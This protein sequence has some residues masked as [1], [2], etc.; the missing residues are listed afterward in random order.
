MTPRQPRDPDRPDPYVEA[1]RML[2]HRELSTA[3]I[4]ERLRERGHADDRTALVIDRL[5][6]ERALD[7]RRTALACARTLVRLK[8][9]GRLRV[10]RELEAR[11]IDP[12]TA[13]AAA[14]EV[15]SEIDERDVL[16]EALS[17]RL[18]G[19]IKDA[20]E[21]RRLY[22]YLIRQGFSA[23]AAIEALKAKAHRGAVPEP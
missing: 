6:R 12:A 16:T 10:L 15:F 22:A 7:D 23:A 1:L 3:E 20:G 2:A 13:R 21:F 18:R 4:R 14:G 9:Q 17:R 5:Q 19:P 8:H 11:G